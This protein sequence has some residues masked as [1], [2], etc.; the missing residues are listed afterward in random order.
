LQTICDTWYAIKPFAVVLYAYGAT[1]EWLDQIAE[2]TESNYPGLAVLWVHPA[3][4]RYIK[5]HAT[6][7]PGMPILIIQDRAELLQEKA[8]LRKTDYYKSWH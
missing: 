1:E 4:P 2:K 6:P 5:N 7:N 3:A 8:R